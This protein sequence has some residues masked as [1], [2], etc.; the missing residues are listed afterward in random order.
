MPNQATYKVLT[1]QR[2]N[3][4]LYEKVYAFGTLKEAKD[5]KAE[6]KKQTSNWYHLDIEKHTAQ[7]KKSLEE[8]ELDE[9][10]IKQTYIKNGDGH[11]YHERGYKPMKKKRGE[12]YQ[13]SKHKGGRAYRI[14]TVNV[15]KGKPIK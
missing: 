3:G 13:G 8:H 6:L 1:K 2:L 11:T 15:T 7:G 9:Y 5:K 14:E 10:A 4:K 12:I